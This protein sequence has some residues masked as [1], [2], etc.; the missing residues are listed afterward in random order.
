MKL[1]KALKYLSGDCCRIISVYHNNES[2]KSYDWVW[3]GLVDDIPYWALN[4]KLCK[5]GGGVQVCSKLGKIPENMDTGMVTEK[6]P[7]DDRP[8]I[9]FFIKD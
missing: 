4:K 2:K 9:M 7:F 1:G 6:Y 3:S 5:R 8:G